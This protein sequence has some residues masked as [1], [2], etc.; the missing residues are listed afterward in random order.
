MK[1]K[2]IIPILIFIL[3][4]IDYRLLG[5]I[6]RVGKMRALLLLTPMVFVQLLKDK[7]HWAVLLFAGYAVT[8][9]AHMNFMVYGIMEVTMIPAVVLFA[10]FLRELDEKTVKLTFMYIGVFNALYGILQF[11]GIHLLYRPT[12]G[13]FLTTPI[14]FMGQHT[15]LGA[16][17]AACL[18]IALWGSF[19]LCALAMLICIAMTGSSMAYLST[20]A[21]LNTYLFY[22]NKRAGNYLLA[23]T[24]SFIGIFY[25]VAP[26]H[27]F[28]NFQQRWEIW[29]V[30][31][32]AFFAN[33]IF[34]GGPGYW[35]GFWQP[36]YLPTVS[37][38][39]F[40]PDNLHSDLLT[41]LVHYGIIGAA[42]FLI[43]FIVFVLSYKPTWHRATCIAIMVNGL[44]NFPLHFVS[45]GLIF[46]YSLSYCLK[47]FTI[48]EFVGKIRELLKA[49]CNL[50]RGR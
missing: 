9:W 32:K 26:K 1:N 37:G 45:T 12:D 6:F 39:K 3:N 10:I 11:F 47:D 22:L 46:V 27:E 44:A 50:L 21:V 41:L 35:P 14:A 15:L 48:E 19:Y 43:A 38:G 13:W 24:A 2:F 20:Y 18:P 8:L 40:L 49:S 28:F 7:M 31:I 23:A 25:L 30:G 29:G 16:F 34:G 5:D 33:P 4:A 42:L 17:L 36:K